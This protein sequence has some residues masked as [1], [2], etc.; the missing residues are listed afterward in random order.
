[1]TI[2]SKSPELGAMRHHRWAGTRTPRPVDVTARARRSPAFSGHERVFEARDDAT[3]L[4]AFIAIHSRVLG[5]ALGGCRM[6]SYPTPEAALTEALKLSRGMTYKAAAAGLNLGGGKAV[7]I[8]DPRTDKSDALFH[9]FGAVVECLGGAYF[10]GEDVG[11]T[12]ADMDCVAR[13]T[14]FVFGTSENGGDPSEMTALGVVAALRIAIARRHGSPALRDRVIAVQG[15]GK[16]GLSLCRL[17]A[18]EG[19]K[20][21]VADVDR[22]RVS[23]A[24]DEFGAE[25]VSPESLH[26]LPADALAPCALGA[27]L[28]R[29]T[30][31]ELMANVVAG[32]ANNQLAS[33]A[34]GW[35]LHRRGIVYAPDYVANAG[36]LISIA[37]GQIE[38]ERDRTRVLERVRR[39]GDTLKAI[40]DQS[41][42]ED[43]PTAVVADRLAERRLRGAP[44]APDLRL[45]G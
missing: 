23:R 1:M 30:I 31:P 4:H 37:A 27:I 36:G 20:L 3:G 25:A 15:L 2:D 42:R 14:A 34:D 29:D 40:F 39:I 44:E 8:G 32:S 17:L 12:V 24:V 18:Q 10:T 35:T 7:I 5:P 21:T 19:G 6:W 11:T 38:G 22:A 43:L 33:K 28:N 26:R 41:E 45:A 13:S 16:V 9:A